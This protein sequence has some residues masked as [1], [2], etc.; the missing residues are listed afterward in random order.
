[1]LARRSLYTLAAVCCLVGVIA[2]PAIAGKGGKPG[3]AAQSNS[4]SVSGNTVQAQGLP[5]DQ[6]INFMITDSS[7]TSGWVLGFTDDGSWSVTV[8]TR[9]GATTYEFAS[10]TWGNG[11]AHYTTFASCSA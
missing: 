7:G 1:V 4:C 8:P 3:A 5:T 11:G 10:K 9:N 6:V 2:T